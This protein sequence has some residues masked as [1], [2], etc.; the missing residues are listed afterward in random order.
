MAANFQEQQKRIV[1]N[2]LAENAKQIL[3]LK[4]EAVESRHS[5]KVPSQHSQKDSQM[6][7][8]ALSGH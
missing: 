1:K 5:C 4:E 7:H 2:R 6:K 3:N 8:L